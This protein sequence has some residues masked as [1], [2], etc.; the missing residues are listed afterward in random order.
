MVKARVVLSSGHGG[1]VRG[2]RASRGEMKSG[3]GA[4]VTARWGR[5]RRQKAETGGVI[6]GLQGGVEGRASKWNGH[7]RGREKQGLVAAQAA[8]GRQAGLAV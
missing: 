7:G 6:A 5:E 4:A 8:A 1:A 2:R 3:R